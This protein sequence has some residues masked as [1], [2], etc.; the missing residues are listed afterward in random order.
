MRV[1]GFRPRRRQEVNLVVIRES[2]QQAVDADRA[3]AVGRNRIVVAQAEN[4]H[5]EGACLRIGELEAR[6]DCRGYVP[7]DGQFSLPSTN[8]AESEPLP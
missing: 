6:L 8:R 5:S 2:P 3:P 7:L 4:P 1:R